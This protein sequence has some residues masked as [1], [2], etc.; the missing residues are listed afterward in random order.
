MT[1][2]QLRVGRYYSTYFEGQGTFVFRCGYPLWMSPE[3]VVNDTGNFNYL[4]D[5]NPSNGFKE[6]QEA[7]DEQILKLIKNDQ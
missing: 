4:G 2:N 6:F 7:T 5:F 3:G 1:Y